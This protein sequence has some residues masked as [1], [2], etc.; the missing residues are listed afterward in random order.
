VIFRRRN[1]EPDP[2]E[3]PDSPASPDSPAEP[4]DRWEALD[5]SRDWREDGPFD[6]D[7]VDLDADEVKRL[8][9]GALIVTPEPGLKIQ[10][11]V[12]QKTKSATTL[13]VHS[14]KSALEVTVLAAPG[15]TGFTAEWRERLLAET[16]ASKGKASP[17]KGPFG[18]ELRW[19]LITTDDDGKETRRP[20]RDW[21]AEGPR[22]LLWARLQGEAATDVDNRGP[23]AELEEFFRNLIVRRGETALIPGTPVS[24]HP[25]E[26]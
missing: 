16:P 14:D 19:T 1:D 17:A 9:L 4:A 21:F 6:I 11:V 3:E 15:S 24:L 7:E 22:W 20:R 23:A 5:L 25:P 26:A 2:L 13:T 12:D 18:T 10:L 8:D